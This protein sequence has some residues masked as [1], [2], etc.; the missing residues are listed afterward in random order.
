M[1]PVAPQITPEL[2]HMVILVRHLLATTVS[3]LTVDQTL[4]LAPV[5]R[6][7]LTRV[8]T[9]HLTLTQALTQVP[10]IRAAMTPVLPRV[11]VTGEV[12]YSAPSSADCSN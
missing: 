7:A 4:H 5:I 6:A 9:I 8:H 3:R 10:V 12:P 11:V 1:T 2:R